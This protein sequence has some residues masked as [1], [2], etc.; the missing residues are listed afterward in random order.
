MSDAKIQI[1]A[2]FAN[3][4]EALAKMVP[5]FKAFGQALRPYGPTPEAA[6]ELAV[7]R[8]AILGAGW[9][10]RNIEQSGFA[11]RFALLLVAPGEFDTFAVFEVRDDVGK[12]VAEIPERSRTS[13]EADAIEETMRRACGAMGF[14]DALRGMR[15]L[16]AGD[17]SEAV[18]IALCRL[19]A[20]LAARR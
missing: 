8:D 17:V 9:S 6:A 1:R 16:G 2:D 7:A 13:L 10:P 19:E 20:E 18:E 5:A 15:Q 12:W 11:N 14:G 3:F 4:G